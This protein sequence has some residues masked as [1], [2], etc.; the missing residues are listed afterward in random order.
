MKYSLRQIVDVKIQIF[1]MSAEV[2]LTL[3]VLL[4]FFN[5]NPDAQ[6]VHWVINTTNVLLEPF[7]AVFTNLG[8]AER[9]WVVDYPAL[10]AMASYAIAGVW[11]MA[12][13]KKK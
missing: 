4:R 11:L 6:F 1:V 9:G 13:L 2:L 5:G 10:L 3:R 12:Y 8:V 7:R